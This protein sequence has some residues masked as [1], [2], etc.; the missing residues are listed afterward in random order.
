[1]EESKNKSIQ[2]NL[3]IKEQQLSQYVFSEWNGVQMT[4]IEGD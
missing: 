4:Q 2:K 3:N 1:M